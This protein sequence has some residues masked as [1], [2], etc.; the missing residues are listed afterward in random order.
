MRPIVDADMLEYFNVYLPFADERMTLRLTD[1][2]TDRW[3]TAEFLVRRQNGTSEYDM[4]AGRNFVE[5]LVPLED[6]FPVTIG[7]N[8]IW[9]GGPEHIEFRYHRLMNESPPQLVV[10]STH[11]KAV[12][13]KLP[14]FTPDNMARDATNTLPFFSRE[15]IDGLRK[16]YQELIEKA[17]K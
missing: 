4:S 12:F 17:P 7:R 11:L 6:G 3:I 10:E 16:H 9:A 14:M 1:D 2:P 5:R 15:T 13:Q 8:A